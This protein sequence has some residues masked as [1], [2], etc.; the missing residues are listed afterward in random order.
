MP[1]KGI[2]LQG[3][4]DHGV[5]IKMLDFLQDVSVMVKLSMSMSTSTAQSY[6]LHVAYHMLVMLVI[7]DGKGV[8]EEDKGR[9]MWGKKR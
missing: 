6:L 1:K 7:D 5:G 3:C 8:E 2:L 9:K 4:A